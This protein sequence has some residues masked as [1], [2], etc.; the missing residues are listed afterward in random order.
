[1]QSVKKKERIKKEVSIV[2]LLLRVKMVIVK[3]KNSPKEMFL[4]TLACQEFEA[5]FFLC[6]LFFLN[7]FP[8]FSSMKT[9]TATHRAPE[10]FYFSWA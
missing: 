2:P 4:L 1:L 8:F 10:R 9:S 5:L 7:V 3:R 6:F